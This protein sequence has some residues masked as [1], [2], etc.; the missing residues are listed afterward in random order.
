MES[1]HRSRRAWP[2]W[3]LWCLSSQHKTSRSVRRAQQLCIA[4][5]RATKPSCEIQ[6][7]VG[8]RDG[9]SHTYL[10]SFVLDS[11]DSLRIPQQTHSPAI[12]TA[13]PRRALALE[14]EEL[15]D[16]VGQGLSTAHLIQ[17]SDP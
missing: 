15:M 3:L 17:T 8:A 1:V 2:A 6:G 16:K 10:C 11:E 13:F 14:N 5:W 9:Q 7:I 4:F 12:P